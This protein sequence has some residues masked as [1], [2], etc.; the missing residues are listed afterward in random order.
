ML[1]GHKIVFKVLN[2]YQITESTSDAVYS[3]FH[4]CRYLTPTAQLSIALLSPPCRVC[5]QANV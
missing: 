5:M 1:M 2:D 3:G 4:P